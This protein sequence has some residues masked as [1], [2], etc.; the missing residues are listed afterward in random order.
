MDP[1]HRVEQVRGIHNVVEVVEVVTVVV[2]S[3][4][5]WSQTCPAPQ[6]FPHVPQF[7]ASVCKFVHPNMHAVSPVEHVHR[8]VV[9]H[10]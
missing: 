7:I 1:A 9:V 5:P 6:K 8:A 4:V 3:H 10:S 2:V